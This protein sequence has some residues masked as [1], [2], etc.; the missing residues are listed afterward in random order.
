MQN[1]PSKFPLFVIISMLVF[2]IACKAVMGA[3]V[4]SPTATYTPMASNPLKPTSTPTLLPTII[5]N[6]ELLF[7]ENEWVSFEFPKWMK[8][9]DTIDPSFA[10][11]PIDLGG[12]LLVGLADPNYIS[13][14]SVKRSIAVFYY[15]SLGGAD[16]DRAIELTYGDTTFHK[17]ILKGDGALFLAGLPAIQKTYQIEADGVSYELRDIWYKEDTQ[18]YRLSIWTPYVNQDDF[19]AFQ[20]LSDTLIKS[21][22]VKHYQPFP[23]QAPTV[24]PTLVNLTMKILPFENKWVTFDYPEGMKPC[25]TSD[26]TFMHHPFSFKG[27][28]M[29]GIVDSDY[30]RGHSFSHF[31]GV[32]SFPDGDDFDPYVLFEG[33]NDPALQIENLHE[34]MRVQIAGVQGYRSSYRVTSNGVDFEVRDIFFIRKDGKLFRLVAWEEYTDPEDMAIFRAITERVI[35]SL[36]IK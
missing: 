27:E 15:P 10:T 36:V 30:R 20:S 21:M 2:S 14:G 6:A 19:T 12:D 33:Y 28:L 24:T 7:Y 23:Y 13:D 17:G 26:E 25:D 22:K 34:G 8:L 32:I 4:P 16:L 35:S 31:I 9:Y 5:T 11:D 29:A 18:V 1:H 3:L